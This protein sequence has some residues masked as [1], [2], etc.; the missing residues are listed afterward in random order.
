MPRPTAKPVPL[1][2]PPEIDPDSLPRFSTALQLQEIA[3]R[4]YGPISSRT[5]RETWPLE[6]RMFNG[7]LVTA[8]L[9]FVAEAQRR[10]DSAPIQQ[11]GKERAPAEAQA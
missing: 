7:R 6:W 3:G 4:Y 5:I 11:S 10:F 8:T 2:L 9:D 1:H